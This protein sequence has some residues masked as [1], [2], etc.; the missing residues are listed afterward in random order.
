MGDKYFLAVSP[1]ARGCAA[2]V[3]GIDLSS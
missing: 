2:I 1:L 3:I